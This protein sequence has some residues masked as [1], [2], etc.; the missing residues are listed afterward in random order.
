MPVSYGPAGGTRQQQITYY[1]GYLAQLPGTYQ[2]TYAQYDGMTW[3]Q[4]YESIAGSDSSADPKQLADAVLGLESAQRL[5]T[6]LQA[7]TN[8]LGKFV[9]ASEKAIGNTNF[10]AGVPGSGALSGLAAIGDFF[11]RLTQASTWL[12]VAEVAL[13]AALLII[14]LAKLA[15][16][17]PVGRAAAKAGK[18]ARIL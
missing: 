8:T 14:G 6:G 4:L 18:A 12:R 13:G 3:A 11:S 15:S 2:G 1:A 16:N 5:G 7:A 9:G 17:T 10:A